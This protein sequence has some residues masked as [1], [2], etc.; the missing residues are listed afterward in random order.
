M[1]WATEEL[2]ATPV[3][4][5]IRAAGGTVGGIQLVAGVAAAALELFDGDPDITGTLVDTV[6]AAANG[7]Q[8]K[9]FE[10]GIG[11]PRGIYVQMVGDGAVAY[12]RYH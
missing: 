9:H 8:E 10:T 2:V 11:L 3:R 4:A 1:K 7:T 5:C 12:V 6:E